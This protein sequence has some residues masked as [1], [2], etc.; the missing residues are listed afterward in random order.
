MEI[1]LIL[2]TL[3]IAVVGWFKRDSVPI[4]ITVTVLVLFSI[5]A[6]F[7]IRIYFKETKEKEKIKYAGILIPDRRVL[8]SGKKRIYPQ[9]E[10]GDCGAIFSFT[11]EQGEPQFSFA[12]DNDITMVIENGSLKVSTL[13]RSRNGVIAELINNEWKVNQSNS[14]DRNF[15]KNSLEVK[16]NNGE[17]IFQVKHV[18]ARIQL[19]G[20]FYGTDGKGIALVKDPSGRGGL[21]VPLDP[22]NGA[23]LKI[24]PIFKYPS[25]LHLGEMVE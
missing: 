18:G 5:V 21:I 10:I 24:T 13:V 9:L 11:N 2:I 20:K 16:D 8:L 4:Y 3:I 15:S 23:D 12:D 19:Q 6:F 22:N 7:Q 25:E 14:F 17:I 1:S